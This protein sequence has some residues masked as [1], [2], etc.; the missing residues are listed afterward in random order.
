[1]LV[2]T[3]DMPKDKKLEK[4]GFMECIAYL[5]ITF[6]SEKVAKM[7]RSNNQFQL[8]FIKVK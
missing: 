5:A 2:V 4:Q 8:M 7:L 6:S 3:V 1:M